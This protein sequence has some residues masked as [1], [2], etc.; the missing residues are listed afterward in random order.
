MSLPLICCL[1]RERRDTGAGIQSPFRNNVWLYVLVMASCGPKSITRTFVP[2]ACLNLFLP[3]RAQKL[4]PCDSLLGVHFRFLL[5]WCFPSPHTLCPHGP[6]QA[7]SSLGEAST[8]RACVL[9][10]DGDAVDPASRGSAGHS[11]PKLVPLPS[12]TLFRMWAWVYRV[13]DSAISFTLPPFI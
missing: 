4:A 5:C 10:E 9:S 13:F 7:G 1:E 11:F 12:G 6:L 3:L 2:A 8:E